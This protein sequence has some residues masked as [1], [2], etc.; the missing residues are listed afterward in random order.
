[1]LSEFEQPILSLTVTLYNP[2][3]KL[4]IVSLV[5]LLLHNNV[6]FPKPPLVLATK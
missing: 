6:K 2:S 4:K 3:D 5:L 1:M